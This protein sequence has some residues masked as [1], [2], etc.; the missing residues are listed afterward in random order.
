MML[1]LTVALLLAALPTEAYTI[2]NL[3][4]TYYNEDQ[5]ILKALRDLASAAT[6]PS[7]KSSGNLPTDEAD[8][9]VGAEF[10]MERWW[11]PKVT[12]K[13]QDLSS[14][15]LNSFGLRYGK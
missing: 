9:L 5:M 11:M 3:R 12:K 13:R 6:L 10:P 8:P 4:S 14:Y 15:N 7:A 2:R 1:R